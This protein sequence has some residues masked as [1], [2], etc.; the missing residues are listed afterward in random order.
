MASESFRQ[1]IPLENQIRFSLVSVFRESCDVFR[2]YTLPFNMI[3][4]CTRAEGEDS[5]VVT[6]LENNRVFHLHEND[7][8]LVTHGLPQDIRCTPRCERSEIHFRLELY[9]GID[10]FN[11]SKF[12]VSENSPELRREA[13]EIFRIKD[14]VLKL[15]RCTDFALRFCFRHWPEH[16]LY[17]TDE[18]NQFK[19]LFQDI[20]CEI[21]AELNVNDLAKR[22]HYSY[23]TFIRTFSRLFHQTPKEYLQEELYRRAS[24]L[25]LAPDETVKSVSERLRFSSEFNFSRFFKRRSGGLS[26]K[27]YRDVYSY[28]S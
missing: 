25:L 11:G 8:T 3:S 24:Y 15:A 27:E 26:P 17:D 4:I 19:Q 22:M 16:Y 7:I 13:D 1:K 20:P 10:V 28:K 12:R 23:D 6:D 5:A 9:P 14:P 2:K 21:T 18:L